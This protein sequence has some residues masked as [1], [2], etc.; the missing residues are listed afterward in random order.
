MGGVGD[1][2]RVVEGGV[3]DGWSILIDGNVSLGGVV[4][5]ETGLLLDVFRVIVVESVV[6]NVIVVVFGLLLKV[7][8]PVET[9]LGLVS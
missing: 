1:V 4:V 2:A 9:L 3:A 6:V 5:L 8:S 7:P